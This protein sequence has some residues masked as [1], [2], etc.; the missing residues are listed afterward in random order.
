MIAVSTT[1]GE[2]ALVV[3]VVGDVGV[4]VG[5][6]EVTV[7]V[8]VVV[9]VVGVVDVTVGVLVVDVVLL[10]ELVLVVEGVLVEEPAAGDCSGGVVEVGPP[11]RGGTAGRPGTIAGSV[12]RDTSGEVE[13]DD[14]R[15][16]DE[17]A[18]PEDDAES[19]EDAPAPGPADGP[20]S[21]GP[22]DAAGET[23]GVG[24][25]PPR[26]MTTAPPTAT[27]ARA[28]APMPAATTGPGAAPMP[29][30]DA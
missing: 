19:D 18:G 3:E 23:V 15:D 26:V 14:E 13:D 11:A 4:A 30:P 21:D 8:L 25:A 9:V 16:V 20:G 6:V 29:P 10:G 5:L 24:A 22:S 17:A 28:T 12:V 1:V 27:A 2:G 7:G